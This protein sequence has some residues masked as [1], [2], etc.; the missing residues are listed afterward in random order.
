MGKPVEDEE[1]SSEEDLNLQVPSLVRRIPLSFE[2]SLLCVLLR[3]ALEQ[4]DSKV[5]DDHRLVLASHR[6]L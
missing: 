1:G 3:E 6:Y 4:F 2:V 5:N